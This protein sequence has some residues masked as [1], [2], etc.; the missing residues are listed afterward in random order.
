[1]HILAIANNKG[2][3]GKTTAAQNIGAAIEKFSDKRTLLI[4][5]DPQGNLS[6]SFGIHL[7]SGEPHLGHF[8][9]E[10]LSLK[11]VI[12]TYKQSKIDVLPACMELIKQEDKLKNS[13]SYPFT[14]KRLLADN[15]AS[16]DFAVIDCPPALGVLTTLGLI[17]CN[18]YYIPIQAEYFSYQGL[19]NFIHYVKE[20][21]AINPDIR[22]GG[23][24]ANRFN[25]Q[26]KKNYSKAII[27][28]T[29]EQLQAR[30]LKN[31][32]RE[33]ITIT[34][35]QAKGEHIFDYDIKSKGAQD[36][37]ALTKEIFG[38]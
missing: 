1:M 11:E 13:I 12:R 22:L 16:Y 35:A 38:Q 17:A 34:E 6:N 19:K 5:L 7:K 3:V 4:D 32:I 8:L 30:F 37:Y 10:K 31:Y 33:N 23:V 27:E 29:K 18:L 20:I 24:F 36:Y 15:K 14:L 2:G 26:T 25:P 28:A 21:H 9:L